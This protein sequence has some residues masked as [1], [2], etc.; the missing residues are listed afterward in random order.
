MPLQPSSGLWY[1]RG[2]GALAQLVARFNGI[3]EV[4]SSNLVRSKFS[5]SSFTPLFR[6]QLSVMGKRLKERRFGITAF[7][8]VTLVPYLVPFTV[9]VY[10]YGRDTN[11]K[12]HDLPIILKSSN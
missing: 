7:S 4:T 3:E 5:L 9:L 8:L 1:N 12:H 2:Y 6:A 10:G 11:S